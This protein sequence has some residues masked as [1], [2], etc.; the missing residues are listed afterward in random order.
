MNPLASFAFQFQIPIHN[1]G[2]QA[3]TETSKMIWIRFLM[4]GFFID[5]IKPKD[6]LNKPSGL[7]LNIAVARAALL[8]TENHSQSQKKRTP[9]GIFLSSVFYEKG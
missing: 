2:D 9:S 6:D 4:E 7:G 5:P 1:P 3:P 8:A